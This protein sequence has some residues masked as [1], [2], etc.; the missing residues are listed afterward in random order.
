MGVQDRR[1]QKALNLGSMNADLSVL[2]QH[3]Y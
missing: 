3:E 2:G 1:K